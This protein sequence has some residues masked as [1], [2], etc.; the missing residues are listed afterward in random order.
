MY[1]PSPMKVLQPRMM[2]N[3][4]SMF[5]LAPRRSNICLVTAMRCAVSEVN[6]LPSGMLP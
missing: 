6:V 4:G 3:G 1:T 5:A 2:K